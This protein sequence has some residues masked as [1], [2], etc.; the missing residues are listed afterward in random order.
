MKFDEVCEFLKE[1]GFRRVSLD[2][3]SKQRFVNK[4]Y[5]ISVTVE[6]NQNELNAEQIAM[7]KKRL[8]DLGYS[9]E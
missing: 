9:D 5:T 2:G 4:D 3:P 7:I 8:R 6:E 1:K